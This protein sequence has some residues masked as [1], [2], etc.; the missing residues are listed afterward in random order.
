MNDTPTH[1]YISY[2]CIVLCAKKSLSYSGLMEFPMRLMDVVCNL[3]IEQVKFL[4]NIRENSNYIITV[5]DELLGGL[6]RMISGPVHQSYSL[7][8]GKSANSFSLHPDYLNV[9]LKWDDTG[10]EYR[11][12]ILVLLYQHFCLKN[13]T[14]KYA[15]HHL[16]ISA[17][18]K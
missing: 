15:Y 9:F 16:R 12:R 8:K 1:T 14:A 10:T 6:A 3:S 13:I 7:P 11:W 5:Q 17:S 4:T 18:Q 2:T